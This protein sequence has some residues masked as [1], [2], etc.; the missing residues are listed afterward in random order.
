[1]TTLD[2]AGTAGPDTLAASGRFP[3]GP[4]A[5]FAPPEQA[6]AR[7][8]GRLDLVRSA[9]RLIVGGLVG[10]VLGYGGSWL[11][12]DVLGG[13]QALL[14]AVAPLA[15][16]LA[17]PA[18]QVLEL[19]SSSSYGTVPATNPTWLLT[20]TAVF[21]AG[22]VLAATGWRSLVGRGPLEA[23]LHAASARAGGT[24]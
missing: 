2:H 12:V 22:A 6:P 21:V 13:R 18:D 11:A 17:I 5:P 3:A 8:R 14:D 19:L 10:A 20:A 23:L 9:G 16:K 24:R 4:P 7:A 15:G 1:M